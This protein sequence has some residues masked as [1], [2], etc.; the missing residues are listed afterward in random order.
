LHT[1]AAIATAL[2]T[3]RGGLAMEREPE[4]PQRTE[5]RPADEQGRRAGH[6]EVGYPETTRENVEH[7]DPGNGPEERTGLGTEAVPAKAEQHTTEHESGYGGKKNQPRV[8]SDQR[9]AT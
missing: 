6:P 8:S 7:E 5:E 3:I 1:W 9:P 2:D 4:E